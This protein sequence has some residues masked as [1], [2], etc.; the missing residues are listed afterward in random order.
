[1]YSQK[2]NFK[3]DREQNKLDAAQASLGW[4]KEHLVSLK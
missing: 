3:G 4:L 1:T 2:H